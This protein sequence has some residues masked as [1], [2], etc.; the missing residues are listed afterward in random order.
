MRI[1]ET[2][3]VNKRAKRRR[4]ESKLEVDL[5]E[6]EVGELEGRSADS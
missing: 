4:K 2:G 1:E 6:D 5:A 3:G